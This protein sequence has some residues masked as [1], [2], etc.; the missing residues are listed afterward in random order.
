MGKI[1]FKEVKK[2]NTIAI[3]EWHKVR[4]HKFNMGDVEDPQLYAGFGIHNWQQTDKGRFIME[5]GKDHEFHT[6]LDHN[7]YG[8]QCVITCELESKKLS[9]YYL[10]WGKMYENSNYR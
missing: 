10:R 3:E 6:H 7:T 4:V 2:D 9:E 8:Y 1:T 5:H